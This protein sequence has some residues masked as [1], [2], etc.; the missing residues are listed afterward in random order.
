MTEVFCRNCDL[1]IHDAQY[2]PE[3]YATRHGWGHSTHEA[4]MD[5]AMQASVKKLVFFHHDVARKDDDL[6]RILERSQTYLKERESDI[7]LVAAR[8]GMILSLV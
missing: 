8:D 1:L 4:V 2:T 6:D 3:E 7:T 5:L